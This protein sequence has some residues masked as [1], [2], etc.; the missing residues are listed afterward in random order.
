MSYTRVIVSAFGQL[1]ILGGVPFLTYALYQKWRNKRSWR[2]ITQRAG[3]QRCPM[4]YFLY[5]VAFALVV[6]LAIVVWPPP[7]DIFTREGSA[8][9]Q[10]VGLG[11]GQ[12]AVV[13]ALL[14]GVVQT[15]LTEELLFRGLIA[16]SL[17]RRLSVLWA[18]VAQ[19]FIFLLPHLLLLQVMP[20]AWGMLPV[21]FL[22][23]LVLGWLRIKSGSIIG[24]WLVHGAA[25]VTVA[26][27]VAIR[28][29]SAELG[30]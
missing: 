10:F 12:A 16:G 6:V 30:S 27:S 4:R 24:P 17:S 28:A 26:L 9:R 19:A 21:V 18:N 15:G 5:S 11:F 22:G 13:S 14:Y 25:N 29:A 3:L 20:E 2:E 23:A 8:Q 1:L 7:L